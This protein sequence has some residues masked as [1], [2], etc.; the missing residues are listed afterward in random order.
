[1][2]S[3][4]IDEQGYRLNVGI[5]VVNQHGE[6]LW[7]RRVGN[8][9]AWQFP[10]GGISS[11]ET[12][13]EAMYRELTEELGLNPEDV[14]YLGETKKWLSYRLPKQFRRY[15]SKPLCVG[16]KQKWFLLR[17][18]VSDSHINLDKSGTP[19]FDHWR[20]VDYW[21]PLNHVIDFKQT[22]YQKMLKE[23]EKL[24]RN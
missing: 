22:V 23:F 24:V 12:P 3:G 8:P 11:D 2:S 10:Q 13:R 5:V 21:Y 17:L 16:Q 4:V 15:N 14:E 7:G 1:M 18:L 9:N 6:L 19:E 20:W